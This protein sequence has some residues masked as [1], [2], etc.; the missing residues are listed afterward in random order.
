MGSAGGATRGY[1]TGPLAYSIPDLGTVDVPLGVLDKGP[2]S[3]LEVWLR[4]DHPRNSD[5]TLSLVSPAGTTVVLSAKRGGRGRNYGSRRPCGYDSAIFTDSGETPIGRARA[6]F[7]GGE[8]RPEAPLADL[9]G[10]EVSGTWKLRVA[11]DTPGAAGA[12]RCFRLRISRHVLETRSARARGTEAQLSYYEA[13]SVYNGFL[14]QIVRCG[15]R[16]FDAVPKRVRPCNC[17]ADGPALS[18]P[19]G[20]VRVRDL[21]RDGEPEVL[22]DFYSGGAH[23]CFYTDVYRYVPRL[24]TYRPTIRLWGNLSP[25]LVDIGSDGRPEFRTADDRFAYVFTCF[26]CSAFPIQI[27]RFDHGRFVDVTRRFPRLVRRDAA[28]LYA[29]YTLDARNRPD[30]RGILAAW[31][32]DQYLLERG[33]SGWRVLRAA[34]RR[35]ELGRRPDGWA[36]GKAYLRKLRFFLR[37]TGYI[38]T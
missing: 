18:V 33:P 3:Y 13:N 28:R 9:Y 24:A 11:D 26:A 20:P 16:A 1:S 5:L 7:T 25:R 27:F 14:L 34:E 30:L 12:V 21:D 8:L 37:R 32:A 15:R 35:G 6:P 4:I 23:C 2:V 31:L 36:V 19:G 10:E 29:Q 17:F 22:V 38:R